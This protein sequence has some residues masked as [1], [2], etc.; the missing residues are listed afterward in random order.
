MIFFL[1]EVFFGAAGAR[2]ENP[3][4]PSRYFLRRKKLQFLECEAES[5]GEAPE[6]ELY[7]KQAP[8]TGQTASRVF[9][10]C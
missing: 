6:R 2:V 8:D 4:E 1:T 7:R 9:D 10:E 5:A 3:T